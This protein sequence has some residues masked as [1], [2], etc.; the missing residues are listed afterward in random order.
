MKNNLRVN[1]I[2]SVAASSR[3]AVKKE[4]DNISDLISKTVY[5]NYAKSMIAINIKREKTGRNQIHVRTFE[6]WRGDE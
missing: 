3:V 5:N 1:K 2:K 4:N 6:E